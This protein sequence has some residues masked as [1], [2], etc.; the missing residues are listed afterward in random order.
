MKK[1]ID[2]RLQAPVSSWIKTTRHCLVAL[3]LASG[4]SVSQATPITITFA[5]LSAQGS[6]PLNDLLDGTGFYQPW[7]IA[8]FEN[9]RVLGFDGRLPEDGY[10]MYN[11]GP[12]GSVI[13]GEDVSDLSLSWLAADS[14]K[15]FFVELYDVANVLI[16]SFSSIG[17]S[18]GFTSFSATG[19]RKLTFHDDGKQVGIDNLTY[20]RSNIPGIPGTPRE[21]PEPVS[22]ALVGLALAG[23]TAARQRKI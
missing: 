18:T 19:V 17:V 20:T 8:D 15:S 16:D 7:G 12:S 23:L 4:A 1:R 14:D 9:A 2:T 3:A 10:G 5:P 13:F 22:L 21:V 11:E 6:P